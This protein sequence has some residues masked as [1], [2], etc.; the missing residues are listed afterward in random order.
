MRFGLVVELCQCVRRDLVASELRKELLL[1]WQVEVL[2]GLNLF[3][4]NTITSDQTVGDIRLPYPNS[5][6]IKC[7]TVCGDAFVIRR[8]EHKI[9]P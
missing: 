6:H 4:C 9:I 8:L 7:D 1:C 2:V 5:F 3:L